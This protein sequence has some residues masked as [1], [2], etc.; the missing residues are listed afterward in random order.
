MFSYQLYSS[1]NFGPMSKTFE[2]VAQAGY[3]AVEGYG[4]LYADDAAVAATQEGLKATGL[5]MP[6]G[7]FGLQQLETEVD[8]VLGIAR[9]LKMERLYCPYVL[10]EDRPADV[11]GWTAFGERLQKAGA[12]YKAAGYGFGWHNH[13]FEFKPLADGSMPQDRI[14]EGGLGLEWEMDVAWVIRGGAD[15]LVWIDRYKDRI[16]AA[17]VKDIAN[18]GQNKDEDGWA[19]V[20]HGTVDWNTIM[21][22]LRKIGVKHFVMEHDNPKD[23]ARFAARS[24]ASAKSF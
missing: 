15:P 16:T 2:M 8:K 4:A 6:T 14:F 5:T 10:P 3:T 21:A 20:G 12:P 7:H 17:H 23:D 1:R 24:I 19:D 11:A 22:A 13:D 9:A 18:A